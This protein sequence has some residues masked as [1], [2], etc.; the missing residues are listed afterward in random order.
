MCFMMMLIMVFIVINMVV[1]DLIVLCY[2]IFGDF[3]VDNGN[4]NQFNLLVR[5]NYFFYGID[6]NGG[7]IGR[8]CNG[9]IMVDGIGKFFV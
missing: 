1:S 4:N 9:L 6:F 3:L 2:F 5:V 7:F 8:F